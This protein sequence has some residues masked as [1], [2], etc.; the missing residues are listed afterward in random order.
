VYEECGDIKKLQK[1]G[2]GHKSEFESY[3][4]CVGSQLVA[5]PN[6]ENRREYTQ[7]L[8][9]LN[10]G[11]GYAMN[12]TESLDLAKHLALGDKVIKKWLGK[13]EWF[14]CS[15]N[16]SKCKEKE[17]CCSNNCVGKKCAE[18][19]ASEW[20]PDKIP[21]KQERVVFNEM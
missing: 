19:G 7:S 18:E 2:E 9:N 3:I 12:I 5:D 10:K 14:G 17:E 21:I 1:F 15:G 20:I 11:R 13:V 4:F 16:G 8:K 6:K